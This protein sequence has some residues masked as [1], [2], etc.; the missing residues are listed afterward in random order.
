[1]S[2]RPPPSFR[3]IAPSSE[4]DAAREADEEARLEALARRR[5][6]ARLETEPAAEQAPPSSL[7]EKDEGA[8]EPAGEALPA[9]APRKSRSASVPA[10][11][12]VEEPEPQR[13]LNIELP[14][15]VIRALK[16]QAVE[17]DCSVRH[18]VMRALSQAGV[19]IPAAAMVPDGRRRPR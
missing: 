14:V 16:A 3:A 5:G 12:K 8:P 9:P 18:L 1:M 7:P 13:A 15:S 17:E 4:A 11:E 10:P 2:R 19:V 6:V